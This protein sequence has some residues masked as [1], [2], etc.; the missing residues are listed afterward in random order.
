MPSPPKTNQKLIKENALLKQRIQ[1]LEIS[2]TELKGTLEVLRQSEK[3]FRTIADYTPN[4]ESWV[5]LDGKLIWVNPQVYNLLGY[6]EEECMNMPDYPAFFF[7]EDDKGRMMRTFKSALKGS[8]DKN[9]EFRI[10]CKDGSIKWAEVSWQPILDENGENLG[11]RA[12][13]IDITSRKQ[14]EVALRKSEHIQSII[15][16][17]A[18]IG[19]IFPQKNGHIG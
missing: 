2:E 15:F 4:W 12:S 18:P 16:R 1:E 5:D 10:R 8:S 11:H 7:Y 13:M 14:T 17:V 6:T 9:I 19:M 3:R